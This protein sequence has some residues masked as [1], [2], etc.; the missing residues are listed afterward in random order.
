VCFPS[1]SLPHQQPARAQRAPYRPGQ[2]VPA[3]R[4]SLFPSAPLTGAAARPGALW[5]AGLLASTCKLLSSP[6]PASYRLVSCINHRHPPFPTGPRC[7][8][9]SSP[10]AFVC[11][12]PS[13][14]GAGFHM[15][16]QSS[17]PLQTVSCHSTEAVISPAFPPEH[18]LSLPLPLLAAEFPL[19]CPR[20][21]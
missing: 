9:A 16:L 1:S 5:L 17:P 20:Q 21:A 18:F 12:R 6:P 11:A 7:L 3:P 15:H 14:P 13:R 10:R 8:P 19:S 2:A 4:H